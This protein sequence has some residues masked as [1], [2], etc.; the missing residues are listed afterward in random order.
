M[1]NA[2]VRTLL[3]E[4]LVAK[5]RLTKPRNVG[6]FHPRAVST[7]PHGGAMSDSPWIEMSP[8][9]QRKPGG[10][11]GP[12]PPYR[13]S[14]WVSVSRCFAVLALVGIGVCVDASNA[15]AVDT[16]RPHGLNGIIA[17]FGQPCSAQAT[18]GS[19]Y[20]PFGNTDTS[21]NPVLVHV[22]AQLSNEFSDAVPTPTGRPRLGL[23]STASIR[24]TTAARSATAVVGPL[25][26]GVSPWMWRLSRTRLSALPG[27]G[28]AQIG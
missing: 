28:L 23:S 21:G 14:V 10:G 7:L 26:P 22:H 27:T 8:A 24:S 18:Q 2:T 20:I 25:M 15:G 6:T 3:F 19:V 12:A 13:R 4:A 16:P 5:R 1:I 17:Q 9:Y 11:D